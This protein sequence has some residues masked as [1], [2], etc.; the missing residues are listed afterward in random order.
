[1]PISASLSAATRR[2]VLWLGRQ[3]ANQDNPGAWLD[4][5]LASVNPLWV[6]AYTPAQVE[7]VERE[8]ADTLTFTLRP[9][10]RWTG[11]QAGQHVT[12]GVDIDGVRHHRTFSLSSPPTLWQRQGRIT[13][14]IK[15]QPGGRVTPWL[16]QHL[17][18]GQ[19]LALGEAFGDF[20]LP[21]PAQP[22][23]FIAGGSGITPILSQ[24]ETLVAGDAR[25]PMTL[26]YCVR[27]PADVIAAERL[28][29]LDARSPALTVTIVTD[30]GPRS[31]RHLGDAH[32]DTVP[33]LKARQV[34]LCGPQ[35]LMELAES[36]LLQRGLRSS[37]IRRASFSVGPARALDPGTT[38]GT[39][40]FR[41]AGV[42]VDATGDASLLA[43]AEAAG[44]NPRYGCRMGI[45]HQCSCRKTGGT[46]LN[47]LTGKPSGPG[48]ETVQLCVSVPAGPVTLEL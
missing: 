15:R 46:V 40:T 21:E 19:T 22:L 35:G 32:L 26:I 37:Q 8:T 5:L 23:L 34:Y 9:A 18:P 36:Q 25:V 45:C 30:D 12:V 44:L 24:L 10:R 42:S 16:H 27:T 11:F 47:R 31:S 7:R 33:G 13:L 41:R 28:R 39:V 6:Q 1:M 29:A 4:P 43:L 17:T 2:T 20:L 3:L 14:T 48:E 38:G